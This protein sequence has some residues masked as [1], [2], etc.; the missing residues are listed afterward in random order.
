MATN[1]VYGSGNPLFQEPKKSVIKKPAQEKTYTQA[2]INKQLAAVTSGIDKSV[3][4]IQD[5]A[6]TLGYD[7]SSGTPV[8]IDTGG[9]GGGSTGG[10]NTLTAEQY[11][12]QQDA[13]LAADQAL[14]NR[15][16]AF[17]LLRSQ[18]AQ[19]GLELD[20]YLL[21]HQQLEPILKLET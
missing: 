7:I 10:G 15:Q 17:D 18:F 12:A 3:T 11:K 20:L 13:K 9:G 2:E 14:Q 21:E 16:S 5:Y 6:K 1:F 8:K 4:A 19:Y